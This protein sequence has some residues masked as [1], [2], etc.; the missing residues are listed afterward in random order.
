M[1]SVNIRT[2]ISYSIKSPIDFLPSFYFPLFFAFSNI[3]SKVH[4]SM[5]FLLKGQKAAQDDTMYLKYRKSKTSV[6]KEKREK[7]SYCTNIKFSFMYFLFGIISRLA[8]YFKRIVL[9]CCTTKV[10]KTISL[11]K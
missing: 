9:A 8:G 1:W 7:G 4:S 11:L 3:Y 5:W 2:F 10:L 6:V